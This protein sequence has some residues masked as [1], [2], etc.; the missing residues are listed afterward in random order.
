MFKKIS[1]QTT[2]NKNKIVSVVGP[3]K[4]PVVENAGRAIK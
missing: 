1:V 2:E 4:I 3:L